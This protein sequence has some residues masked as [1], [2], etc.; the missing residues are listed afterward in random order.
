MKS[1]VNWK[2]FS[3]Q[4]PGIDPSDSDKIDQENKKIDDKKHELYTLWFHKC[5]KSYSLAS[6]KNIIDALNNIEEHDL[7]SEIETKYSE[8]N[9][10]IPF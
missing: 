3:T 7:A 8:Y 10:C 5:H 9:I 4:L 6:W 2:I 1:L